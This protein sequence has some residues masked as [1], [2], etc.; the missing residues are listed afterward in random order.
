MGTPRT[1]SLHESA[2]SP[3]EYAT[4][5]P[6]FDDL[7]DADLDA[8]QHDGNNHRVGNGAENF[9]PNANVTVPVREARGWLKGRYPGVESQLIDRVSCVFVDCYLRWL[10]LLLLLLAG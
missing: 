7:V 5:I 6:L 4:Y 10:L 3:S 9:N 2:L 1:L 8:P